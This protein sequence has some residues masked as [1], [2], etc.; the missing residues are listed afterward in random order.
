[1]DTD[2]KQALA[3]TPIFENLPTE[4]LERL[5]LL[6]R[7]EKFKRGE[8]VFK[9]GDMGDKFYLILEGQVRI[10]RDIAGMGEE[11]LTI[12]GPGDCFGEMSLI[13]DLPRSADARVH[14]SLTVLTMTKEA[15]GNLLLVDQ[16]LAYNVLWKFVRILSARL[17]ET[18]DKLT[19]LSV[20]SKFG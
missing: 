11:A 4:H 16:S 14:Q 8:L 13:D 1:M 5:A 7:Q 6:T 10:S 20:S 2:P 12:L 19:F 18:D 3:K 15:L 17:R 9:Q